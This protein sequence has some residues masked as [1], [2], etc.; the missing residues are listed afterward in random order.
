MQARMP[1]R[2]EEDLME[3]GQATI[4]SFVFGLAYTVAKV[5]TRRVVS[6][7]IGLHGLPI[8]CSLTAFAPTLPKHHSAL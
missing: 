8:N 5:S 1:G 4:E 7:L 3:D 6:G 2:G